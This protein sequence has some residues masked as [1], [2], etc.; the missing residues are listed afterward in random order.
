[1]EPYERGAAMITEAQR[2]IVETY[3]LRCDVYDEPGQHPGFEADPPS[4]VEIGR[5]VYILAGIVLE[6]DAILRK[7]KSRRVQPERSA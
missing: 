7:M 2:K 1:M 6:Q 5:A 3:R 4:L